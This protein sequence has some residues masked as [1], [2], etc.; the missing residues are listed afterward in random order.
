LTEGTVELG[1]LDVGDKSNQEFNAENNETKLGQA[2]DN[3]KISR[4]RCM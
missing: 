3:I 4:V 2:R 1:L